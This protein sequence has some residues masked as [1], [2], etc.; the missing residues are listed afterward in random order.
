MRPAASF[1]LTSYHDAYFLIFI[2]QWNKEK[3]AA[4]MESDPLLVTRA[5]AAAAVAASV[6]TAPMDAEPSL[7]QLVP[8]SPLAAPPATNAPSGAAAAA[9]PAT[10]AP[11]APAFSAMATMATPPLFT[12][13]PA[14]G[15]GALERQ[16]SANITVGF[17]SADEV[18]GIAEQFEGYVTCEWDEEGDEELVEEED[19]LNGYSLADVEEFMGAIDVRQSRPKRRP[20]G[21]D[22]D[23]DDGEGQEDGEG[24][25]NARRRLD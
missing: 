15:A 17:A 16:T 4:L 13:T 9:T 11:F 25:T 7:Q 24:P 23:E 21:E 10:P 14:G 2:S 5:A 20:W 19:D 22:L 6:E 12:S 18:S 3:K 8:P 1:F